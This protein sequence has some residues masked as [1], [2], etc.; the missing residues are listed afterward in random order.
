[1]QF[2]TREQLDA[3]AKRRNIKGRS[4]MSKAQLE[5]ALDRR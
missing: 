1:V 3:E 5:S 4:R 2:G